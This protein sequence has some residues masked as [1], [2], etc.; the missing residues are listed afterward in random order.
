MVFVYGKVNTKQNP[1]KEALKYQ[2]CKTL[3]LN[4]YT[5]I[6]L[7]HYEISCNQIEIQ[8]FQEL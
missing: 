1:I 7:N 3:A 6:L 5:T 8:K 2:I 4:I